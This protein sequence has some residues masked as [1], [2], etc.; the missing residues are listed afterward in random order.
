MVEIIKLLLVIVIIIILLRFKWDLGIVMFLASVLLGLLFQLGWE[1]MFND[2]YL[3]ITDPLTL[4]IIGIIIF[5]YLLSSILRRSKSLEAII[6]SLQK[7]IKDYRL[8][9]FFISSFLGLIPM[10]AGAMFSAP[11]LKE[12]GEKN[13]MNRDEIM[14]ANYWF[15]HVWEFIWPLMPGLILYVSVVDIE[16]RK[17]IVIQFPF[18]IIALGIGFFWMFSKLKAPASHQ[19][20]QQKTNVYVLK[21]IKSI[22]S[23]LLIIVLVIFFNLDLLIALVIAVTMLLLFHRFDRTQLKDM[24]LK[25]I[26]FKVVFMIVGIFLFKQTLETTQAMNLIPQFFLGLGVNPW[27]IIFSV[28]FLLGFLTGVATG[29]VGIS[30]PIL[31]PLLVQGQELNISMLMFAFISG[32]TGMMFSPMHLCLTVTRDYFKVNMIS[33]YK[34]LFISLTSFM[35]LSIIYIYLY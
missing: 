14:F 3:T 24:I 33:I 11:L 29:F 26:S 8:I 4:Q 28:P 25:D 17:V 22:W 35:I 15:R 34:K 9:V 1:K 18:T 16:L 27:V 10:P 31:M 20:E 19:V 6:I 30:L 5:V 23:I 13:S 21:F 12:I 32:F 7:I 2:I